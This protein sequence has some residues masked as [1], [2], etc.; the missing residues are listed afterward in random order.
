MGMDMYK[1]LWGVIMDSLATK[2]EKYA[3][4]AITI[5]VNLQPGQTLI[6]SAPITAAQLVRLAAQK[7]YELGAKNVYVE[8][9]DELLSLITYQYA[10]LETLQEFPAWKAQGFAEMAKNGAALLSI[11]A[12][13]PDLLK[14]VDPERVA[15]ANKT[16]AE[17]LEEFNQYVR[18][19]IMN[20]AIISYPTPEWAAK[21]FPDAGEAS[22]QENAVDLLWDKIFSVTRTDQPDPIA[23]WQEHIASLQEK[24]DFLNGKNYKSLHYRGPG[25]DLTVEL[26]DGHLWVGGGLRNQ[27]GT[28]F[29]P[30]LPTEE[31][32]TMPRKEGVN[33]TV[34]STKPLNYGGNLIDNFTFTF[35][36]GKIVSFTADTGYE[37]LKK[38][39]ETDEGSHYLGEVALVPHHSPVSDTNLIFYNT[40]FDENASCHLAIGA[41]YPFTL[42]EGATLSKDQLI[43]RGANMSL[44]HVDFMIGS[45]ELDIDG[46]TVDGQREPLFRNG[47]WVI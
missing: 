11:H 18:N 34:R 45:A 36:K 27:Q 28:F 21:V 30:N 24:L 32:F 44:M 46:I 3:E 5:G 7:A 15:V 14:N 6:I 8:W 10:P 1:P 4:L 12:S 37:T 41:A 33:G 47:N 9:G 22:P 23:A 26:A 17:V 40:L 13:N 35:E 2:L 25:S 29:V 42:Q 31:V 43:E 20:W 39:I 16:R 19:G 38:L